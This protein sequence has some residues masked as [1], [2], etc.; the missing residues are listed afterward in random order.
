MLRI[1][2]I[3]AL[4]GCLGP[5]QAE[6]D[7]PTDGLTDDTD[8]PDTD[9]PEDTDTDVPVDTDTDTDTT[10][11]ELRIERVTAPITAD[12][13]WDAGAVWVLAGDA[14][15]FV[16]GSAVLTIEAGTTVM[17]EPGSALVVTRDA[18]VDARGTADAPIVLT[19]ASPVG[20]RRPGDWGGLVMLGNATVNK[21]LPRAIEGIDAEDVRGQYGGAD[22][23]WNC[24]AL[25]YVRIEFAGFEVFAGNELNGLTL[26]ACGANTFVRHVQI[27]RGLDDGIEVFGGTADLKWV[28]ITG[29][30]DDGFD[31]D[32]GWRGRLQYA[33]IQQY[34]YD[35]SLA[36]NG[37]EGIEGDGNYAAT[38]FSSPSIYNASVFGSGDPFSA[39]YGL[40]LKEGTAGTI[41][42]T[43][44][45]FQT[46]RALD[47]EHVETADLARDGEL[48]I[49]SSAFWSV[50][51]EGDLWALD[52]TDNDG[53][54]DELQWLGSEDNLL[55][56][57]P[58]LPDRPAP[59]VA[60]NQWIV[61]P[62]LLWVPGAGSPLANGAPPPA[63]DFFDVAASFVGAIRPASSVTWWDG[64]TSFPEN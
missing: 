14:I 24:G 62:S 13:V 55:G 63:D 8:L 45:A 32:E 43:V 3:L 20:S 16:E 64:W 35:P 40:H 42:N 22:D 1:L 31:Y 28:V 30:G 15:L 21:T 11:T 51:T 17:G 18:R 9:T 2:L 56:E 25:D 4:P 27:H 60:P 19:S 61:D 58:L 52:A 50:G 37:D 12:T 44:V 41:A 36:N 23:S 33:V 57:D 38:P 53:G 26:G 39:Q 59:V 48:S 47:V 6:W 10:D 7:L 49:S 46:Q 5:W 34:P 54:F 29:S